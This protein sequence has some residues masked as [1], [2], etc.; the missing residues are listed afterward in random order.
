MKCDVVRLVCFCAI[1][2]LASTVSAGWMSSPMSWS[3]DSRWL[4]YTAV[5][6]PSAE[7]LRPGWLVGGGEARG[8]IPAGAAGTRKDPARPTSFRIWAVDQIARSN[9]LIEESRWPLSAP[10]WGGRSLAFTRFVPES[11]GATGGS[12]GGRLEVVVERSLDEKRVVWTSPEF[13]LDE[14]ARTEF[15]NHRCAWS[16]D[17]TYLAV[18]RQG[19]VPSVDIIRTDT[20]KRVHILDHAILPVWSPSGTMCAYIRQG[21]GSHSLEIVSRRGQVFTKPRELLSTGGVTAAPF[22]DSD[23]RSILVVTAKATSQS[24]EFELVRCALDSSEREPDEVLNLVPDPI[25]RVARLRGIAIDFDKDGE[26]SFHAPDLENREP[27]LVWTMLSDPRHHRR[28]HP[29]D[30]SLRIAAVSV[31]PNGECAA[32]RFGDPDALSHPA[33]CGIDGERTRLLAPDEAARREWLKILSASAARVL[34]GGLPSVVLDG[35]T[36]ERPTILPLPNELPGLGNVAARLGRIA[37]LG[38]G[39][40]PARDAANAG[41]PSDTEVR[42]LFD[43]LRG[44]TGAATADLD[45]LEQSTTDFDQ[46]LSLLS[47][48]AMVRWAAGDHGQAKQIIAYL[49]SST[50]TT[51]SRVEDTPSGPVIEKV[52][53]PEQAWAT[54][55][56]ARAAAAQEQGEAPPVAEKIDPF[57]PF[58]GPGQRRLL[59]L[60]E[61]PQFEPGG[62]LGPFAPVPAPEIDLP[63]RP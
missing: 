6:D 54:F 38:E 13:V 53:C 32:V 45:A 1:L 7:T 56:S 12:Q 23:S 62:A 10:A 35:K 30:P 20:G 3:P 52:V 37:E 19:R 8:E 63:A 11:G 40:L 5:L 60:P 57:D 41:A 58:L 59:E 25:K 51:T 17:G 49:V 26:V 14:A 46:R 34:R 44:D 15:P 27:E 47:I 33:L 43:Y 18:P 42:L 9:V 61:F 16:P 29:V 4:A 39:L 48:R 2:C 24:R 55:I 28:F 31:S 22:W 21:I 50:G 36:Y